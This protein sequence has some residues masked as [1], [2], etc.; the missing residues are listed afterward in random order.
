ME[1][2]CSQTLIDIEI[3]CINDGSTDDSLE[4]LNSYQQKDGRILII[5]QKNMGVAVAR[6]SGLRLATGK[7][8]GF[9]DSDDTVKIDFFEILFK[10]AENHHADVVLSKGLSDSM[11]ISHNKSYSQQEI[12]ELILPLYFKE[13][14]HNAIWNK[15]YSNAIIKKYSIYFPVGK[16]HGEDAE[17]NIHFLM[18]AINLYVIDYS[19]YHYRETQGSATRNSSKFDYLQLALETFFK[20][21]T[22]VLGETITPDTMYKLKKERF[23]NNVISLI[24]IYSNPE[25]GLPLR[26]RI[27][28]LLKIVD[29]DVVKQLFNENNELITAS[30][31]EYK[32]QIYKGIHSKSVIKLYLLS[33]YSYY[34][35]K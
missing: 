24:Y 27:S 25:N 6:N 19:G 13:D 28:R 4:I 7:Y 12:R 5:D 18:H 1:S 26:A 22:L 29:H 3:I 9:L 2:I 11:V 33:L 32:K 17:F 14:G 15:L 31:P 10:A 8:I 20:D 34:R 16:T 21:W 30:F 23:I 35:S